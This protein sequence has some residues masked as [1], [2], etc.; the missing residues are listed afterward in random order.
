MEVF[1]KKLSLKSVEGAT[2][3]P[4]PKDLLFLPLIHSVHSKES[5]VKDIV[6]ANS[7]SSMKTINTHTPLSVINFLNAAMP[8]WHL[9]HNE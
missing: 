5:T 6:I 3:L 1:R 8:Q 2:N 4:S 9:D 7:F